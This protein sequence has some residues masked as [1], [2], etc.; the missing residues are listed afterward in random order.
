LS[1]TGGLAKVSDLTEGVVKAMFM[2]KIKNVLAV[3]LV[4]GLALGGIG[5]GV[6]LSTD[7]AVAQAETPKEAP[8]KKESPTPP[9]VTKKE[10]KPLHFVEKP[11]M[12]PQL[13]TRLPYQVEGEPTEEDILVASKAFIA[14]LRLP[15]RIR[16]RELLDPRYLK[17]H[18][19]TDRDIAYEVSDDQGL[20]NY[21]VADDLRTVLFVVDSKGGAKELIIV[22][23]AVY[24]GHIYISP[25]KAPD[26]KT[27]I[28][29][30]WIL[31]CKVN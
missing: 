29:K 17:K 26:S 12:K 25:E 16:F 2:T 21:H 18:G 10:E 1:I 9:V 19:L 30:P 6:G 28:F 15:G 5:L 3:V 7:P 11:D 31:R 23:W 14:D 20:N 13:D 22:R 8:G 27:G 24:E 4:V